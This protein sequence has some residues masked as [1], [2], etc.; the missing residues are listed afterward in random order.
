MSAFL[1][2]FQNDVFLGLFRE[3][4]HNVQIIPRYVRSD[5]GIYKSL[6]NPISMI[7]VSKFMVH[8]A[9]SDKTYLPLGLLSPLNLMHMFAQN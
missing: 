9:L 4:H 1:F 8:R 6:A 7:L 3:Y 5:L 2:L